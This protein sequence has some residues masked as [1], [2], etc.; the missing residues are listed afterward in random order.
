MK[1]GSFEIRSERDVFIVAEIGVN[2]EGNLALAKQMIHE[3]AECGV[4]AVKFQTYKAE[5]YV[6]VTE[7]ERFERVKRFQLSY[8]D[9]KILDD[10]A[11]KAGVIFFSTPVDLE[12]VEVLNEIVPFFKISSG[13]ITY[14][15]LIKRV[16][17]KGKPII[18]S[19]GL[20]TIDEISKAVEVIDST[21]GKEEELK[22]RL[23]LMHCNASY[24]APLDEV[25]LL[26]VPFLKE[27]F[28]VYSGYSDHTLGISACLGA[29]ALG[30]VVI[31]KHF[32]YRKENQSFRDHRLSADKKEMKQLVTMAKEIRTAV[33]SNY[34]KNIGKTESENKTAMRRG[35]A[36]GRDMKKGDILKEEDIVFLRPANG[37]SIEYLDR[38]LNRKILVDKRGGEILFP[39]DIEGIGIL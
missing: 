30:A 22:D 23:I 6:S 21:N 32:T 38:V 27:R 28:G 31:E 19:T 16:A 33:G 11:K 7:K 4:N 24:P 3:A 14:H 12:S 20:A 26:S 37:I 10:E 2:H 36:A 25:N 5:H 17:E 35:L 15:P 9:F 34:G 13:D 8:E 1:L 39:G 29:V 18:L